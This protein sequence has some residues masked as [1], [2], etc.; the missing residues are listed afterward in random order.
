M[1][2]LSYQ[3]KKLKARTRKIKI[4]L[5]SECFHLD[6]RAY[7]ALQEKPGPGSPPISILDGDL[8][9]GLP[10]GQVPCEFNLEQMAMVSWSQLHPPYAVAFTPIHGVS[11][12]NG[13][14]CKPQGCELYHFPYWVTSC[15]P[16]LM[17]M[18]RL[19]SPIRAVRG[20]DTVTE[21]D[22]SDTS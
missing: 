14:I 17:I 9:M 15:L 7:A 19:H 10:T 12:V 4:G 11:R 20:E 18:H 1:P 6:S 22:G 16:S 2:F 21:S 5:P 3:P 8:N 13:V